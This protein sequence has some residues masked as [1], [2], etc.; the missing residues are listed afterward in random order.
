MLTLIVRLLEV[1]ERTHNPYAK[2]CIKFIVCD[3]GIPQVYV[4]DWG[5]TV[6]HRLI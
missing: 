1:M 5:N 4:C 2:N 6:F 3:G